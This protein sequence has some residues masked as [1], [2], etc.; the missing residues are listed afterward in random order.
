MEGEGKQ[1][2]VAREWRIFVGMEAESVGERASGKAA[3]SAGRCGRVCP[4]SKPSPHHRV[5]VRW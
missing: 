3:T 2:E 1:E 5:V 4:C